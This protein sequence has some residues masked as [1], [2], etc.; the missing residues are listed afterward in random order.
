MSFYGRKLKYQ[1]QVAIKFPEFADHTSGPNL[2]H[3]FSHKS[4]MERGGSG[5]VFIKAEVEQS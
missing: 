4:G 5:A 2:V 1:K 3:Y